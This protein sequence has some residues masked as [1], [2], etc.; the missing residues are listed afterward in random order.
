MYSVNE[1]KVSLTQLFNN[2]FHNTL[3][4][5]NEKNVEKGEKHLLPH[6]FQTT[7]NRYEMKIKRL[8]NSNQVIP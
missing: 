3:P 1:K 2:S 5:I 7:R 4:L 6:K 8:N